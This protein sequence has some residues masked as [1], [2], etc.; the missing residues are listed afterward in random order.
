MIE[1]VDDEMRYSR[2]HCQVCQEEAGK[3][4]RIRLI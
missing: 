1:V 3:S 4:L 2:N